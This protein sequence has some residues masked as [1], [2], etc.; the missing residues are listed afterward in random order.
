MD[1]FP[2]M[3]MRLLM[4][5]PL[6]Y[7]KCPFLRRRY[8]CSVL[9]ELRA[10]LNIIYWIVLA[11]DLRGLSTLDLD[12]DVTRAIMFLGC[13]LTCCRLCQDRVVEGKRNIYHVRI[14]KVGNF[15]DSAGC[16]FQQSGRPNA[17]L[18]TS[19]KSACTPR[20]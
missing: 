3:R 5:V 18:M 14:M 10:A 1:K 11:D 15:V 12:I 4:Y 20:H 17:F 7:S 2:Y 9:Q 19:G 13:F 16:N 8:I 6:L